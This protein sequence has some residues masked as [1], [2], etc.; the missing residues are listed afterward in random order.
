MIA[1]TMK[2]SDLTETSNSQKELFLK[3]MVTEDIITKEQQD[4]MNDYCFV[5]A[6]KSYFGSIWDKIFWNTK[7]KERNVNMIVVKI[8]E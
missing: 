7:E 8:V 4:K 6:E 3:K 1:Y 2:P 5:I